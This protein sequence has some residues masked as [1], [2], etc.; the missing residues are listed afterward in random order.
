VAEGRFRTR[1]SELGGVHET[2]R[3]KRKIIREEGKAKSAQVVKK[4]K[5]E[6]QISTLGGDGGGG[7][8]YDKG[9]K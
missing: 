9:T 4:K 3:G 6:G 2:K 1:K 7:G 5:R 8:R